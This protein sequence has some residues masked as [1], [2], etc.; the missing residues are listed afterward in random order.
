MDAD[1]LPLGIFMSPRHSAT[2][3]SDRTTKQG[4]DRLCFISRGT[5]LLV[6]QQMRHVLA[7]LLLLSTSVE[8][9]EGCKTGA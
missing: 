1:T 6:I 5:D 2:M 4:Q 3:A 7:F 8:A 9:R